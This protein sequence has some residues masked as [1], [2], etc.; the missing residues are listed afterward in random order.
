MAPNILIAD[1]AVKKPIIFDA[2]ARGSL[3]G[4]AQ[5]N[6][7]T[8]VFEY[9]KRPQATKKTGPRPPMVMPPPTASAAP[10][11]FG[12]MAPRSGAG[13]VPSFG[14]VAPT[15]SRTPQRAASSGHTAT[16]NMVLLIVGMML[17][18]MAAK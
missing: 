9:L 1:V 14:S 11:S 18:S 15:T 2:V 12:G 10:T 5:M 6:F 8:D 7:N 4:G 17:A 3:P 16:F 13:S